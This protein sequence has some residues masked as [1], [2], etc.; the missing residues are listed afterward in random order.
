[1]LR[2]HS[3][4]TV[5]WRLFRR[6]VPRLSFQT[7]LMYVDKR[8]AAPEYAQTSLNITIHYRFTLGNRTNQWSILN[9]RP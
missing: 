1:M 6:M 2:E 3:F 8:C 9:A 5:S 7:R 4:K